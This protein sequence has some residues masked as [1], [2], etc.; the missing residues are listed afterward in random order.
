VS[1]VI[2]FVQKSGGIQYAETKMYE[3]REKSL[4]ILETFPESS[5]RTSLINLVRYTTERKH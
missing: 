5:S 2:S 4:A 3:Y 1:E